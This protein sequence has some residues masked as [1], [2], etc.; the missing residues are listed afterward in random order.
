MFDYNNLLRHDCLKTKSN[1]RKFPEKCHKILISL[2]YTI[3]CN[4][5]QLKCALALTGLEIG[6]QERLEPSAV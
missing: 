4:H 6:L 3:N 5:L 2:W 1:S